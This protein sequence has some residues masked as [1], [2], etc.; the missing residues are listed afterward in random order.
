MFLDGGKDGGEWG[1]G[2][3][4]GV[5]ELDVVVALDAGF[6]DDGAADRADEGSGE[7]VDIGVLEA[8][9]AGED[10]SVG[11]PPLVMWSF[12]SPLATRRR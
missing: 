2:D 12:G 11:A 9:L 6:V 3:A 5:V 7:G 4:F 10:V 8:E 1:V